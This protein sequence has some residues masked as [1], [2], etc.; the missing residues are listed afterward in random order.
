MVE[1]DDD[2]SSIR[3]KEEAKAVRG[4][5][6]NRASGPDG[7][8]IDLFKRL[9]QTYP[10]L[11]QPYATIFKTGNFPKKNVRPDNCPIR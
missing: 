8:P 10:L 11:A 6:P 9:T 7:Y 1:S 4:L 5:A 2:F 3:T